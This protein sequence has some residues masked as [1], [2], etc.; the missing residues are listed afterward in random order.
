MINDKLIYNVQFIFASRQLVFN[1]CSGIFCS[2]LLF[3]SRH[4]LL[5]STPLC[6]KYFHV[7]FL[8]FF[9]FMN[10]W[11]KFLA[12]NNFSFPI[13]KR[14]WRDLLTKFCRKYYF[15]RWIAVFLFFWKHH[16]FFNENFI[17]FSW[18]IFWKFFL[19]LWHQWW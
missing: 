6:W 4:I 7:K 10:F 16:W 15:V 12:E 1:Q 2:F 14:W 8:Q 19:S 9:Y 17:V 18:H 13:Y 5:L 11:M 3:A